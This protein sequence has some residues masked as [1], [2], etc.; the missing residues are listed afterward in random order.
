MI[1]WGPST[2]LGKRDRELFYIKDQ[3]KDYPE[4]VDEEIVMMEDKLQEK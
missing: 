1:E 4:K 3:I 2:K